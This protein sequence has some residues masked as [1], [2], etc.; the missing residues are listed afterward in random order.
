M[1]VF[2]WTVARAT[3]DKNDFFVGGLGAQETGEEHCQS[4]EQRFENS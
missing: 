3:G 4:G 2:A 1:F